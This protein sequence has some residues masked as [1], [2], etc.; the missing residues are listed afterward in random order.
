VIQLIRRGILYSELDSRVLT[1]LWRRS[2]SLIAIGA[3]GQNLFFGRDGTGPWIRYDRELIDQNREVPV[4]E[5]PWPF[6]FG[7]VV[8]SI[9]EW[10]K[11]PTLLKWDLTGSELLVLTPGRLDQLTSETLDEIKTAVPGKRAQNIPIS[12][13]IAEGP[14]L[15][16]ARTSQPPTRQVQR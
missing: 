16:Q 8:W 14:A 13:F 12:D 10:D 15:D 11:Q 5:R 4:K 6:S 2:K 3:M 7:D 1:Y 9:V